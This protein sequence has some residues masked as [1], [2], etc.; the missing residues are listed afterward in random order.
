MERKHASHSPWRDT[1]CTWWA[2]CAASSF[3]CIP[4]LTVFRNPDS[5]SPWNSPSLK[6]GKSDINKNPRNPLRSSHSELLFLIKEK[7][8]WK[9]NLINLPTQSRVEI[10]SG[11]SGGNLLHQNN[12]MPFSILGVMLNLGLSPPSFFCT[13]ADLWTTQK[14]PS[15]ISHTKPPYCLPPIRGHRF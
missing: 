13:D 8:D 11:Q 1:P 2:T 10:I 14:P 3:F 4:R 6:T 7:P 15:S 9:R 5:S 12:S